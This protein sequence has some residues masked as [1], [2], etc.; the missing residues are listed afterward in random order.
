MIRRWG[1]AA[2]ALLLGLLLR[3]PALLSRVMG[4][5]GMVA[6]RN[7]LVFEV[8]RP[9]ASLQPGDYPLYDVLPE[10]EARPPVA[11]L[12]RAVALD[13]ASPIARWGLGRAALATGDAATAAEALQ[14]LSDRAKRNPLLY[15]DALT[16]FS[17]GG[18]PAEV[19]ALYEAVPPPEW[20]R[21]VSDTVAL[22]YLEESR[23]AER[24]GSRG[25][26]EQGGRRALALE[27]A[28]ELRPG[29]LYAN[30][31]LWKQAQ[32]AGD[33]EATAAYSETLI[34]FPLE[35]VQ[36]TDE[37]LLDYIAEVI[38]NLLEDG[39]WDREK[40]L[41]VVSFLVWQH[42]GAVGVERLLEYL[43]ARYPSEPDWPFYLAELYHRQGDLERA[44]LAYRQVL[45]VDSEYAQA[46]LRIGMLYEA[47][48]EGE[49]ER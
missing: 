7:A 25:A 28:R 47:R 24:P 39:L 20:M 17:Y 21:A 19:I 12:R 40:T 35:A 23:G 2:L 36:P 26:G 11:M 9:D 27:R 46:Y 14:P 8:A 33:V 42:D 49:M 44:E 31:F 6:L 37:R 1:V 38:P 10:R 18:E 48:A 5:V 34:Y 43:T 13:S 29:D 22:A 32:E 30:Y 3:G 45:A 16:A 4:N 41:N 15:Y